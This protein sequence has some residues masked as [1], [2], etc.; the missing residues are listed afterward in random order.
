MLGRGSS[1][2]EEDAEGYALGVGTKLDLE[3]FECGPDA[4]GQPHVLNSPKSLR[5]CFSLGIEVFGPTSAYSWEP[6]RL[7]CSHPTSMF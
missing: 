7:L 6:S 2:G 1:T 5:A 3:N 4:E